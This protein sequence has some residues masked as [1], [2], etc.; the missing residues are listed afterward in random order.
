[1]TLRFIYAPESLEGTRY[2][3]VTS[4]KGNESATD[5]FLGMLVYGLDFVFSYLLSDGGSWVRFTFTY[6]D[7]PE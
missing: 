5:L 6:G 3:A 1:M 4:C 2:N 7:Y